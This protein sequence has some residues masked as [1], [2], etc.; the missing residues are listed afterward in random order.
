MSAHQSPIVHCTYTTVTPSAR[1]AYWSYMQ[2]I[3]VLTSLVVNVGTELSGQTCGV[4]QDNKF[5]AQVKC[6]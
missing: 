3:L 4:L 1:R 5:A 2:L 6:F